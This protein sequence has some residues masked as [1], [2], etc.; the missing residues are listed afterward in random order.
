M[1]SGVRQAV[2][3][4]I[5]RRAIAEDVLE[6]VVNVVDSVIQPVSWAFNDAVEMYAYDPEQARALFSRAT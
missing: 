5:D 3:H 4:A 6:G 2:A 1:I